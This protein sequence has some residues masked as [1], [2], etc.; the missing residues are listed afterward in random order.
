MAN[1]ADVRARIGKFLRENGFFV[2][3]M[4]TGAIADGVPDMWFTAPSTRDHDGCQ[5]W[6]ELKKVTC[7][8]AKKDT[9]LFRSLNHP[10]G[11]YQINW[12][13]R[14]NESGSYANILVAYQR[15]YFFV[16]GTMADQFND[17][18]WDRL[19][20]Y[21]IKKEELVKRLRTWS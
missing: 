10:L 19:Q 8:P 5:G 3:A 9:S 7:L 12:I 18:T 1:E 14:C 2:Q 11:T 4:E 21:E 15:R 13:N 20:V 6:L 17:F 16:P